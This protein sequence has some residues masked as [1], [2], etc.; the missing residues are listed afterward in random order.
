MEKIPEEL[1]AEEKAKL[2]AS[3]TISDAGLLE[4]GAEFVSDPNATD[5]LRLDI[6]SSRKYG[7]NEMV[8]RESPESQQLVKLFERLEK[9]E[10]FK[11]LFEDP[12]MINS[13]K[14]IERSGRVRVR[15]FVRDHLLPRIIIDRSGISGAADSSDC[16]SFQE[17]YD[18]LLPEE[19]EKGEALGKELESYIEE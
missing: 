10:K 12:S 4:G 8:Q 3:R 6:S 13:G 15:L 19:R 16:Y 14:E 11:D 9:E 7:A 2:T 17:Y 18:S 1:T 5:G